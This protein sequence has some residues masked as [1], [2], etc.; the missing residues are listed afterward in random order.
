MRRL[1]LEARYKTTEPI[2]VLSRQE[3]FAADA[4][5]APARSADSAAQTNSLEQANVVAATRPTKHRILLAED[6]PINQQVALAMLDQFGYQVDLANNGQEALN[7]AARQSYDLVLM[8][9]Q[10]PEM[11]GFEAT[12]RIRALE[13]GQQKEMRWYTPIIA[14]TAHAME[15]DREYCLTAGMDDYMT[16]PFTRQQ[17]T[18]LLKRWLVRD[19]R[20]IECPAQDS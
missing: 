5:C 14:L 20:P 1:L 11:D 17:L 3:Q 16:K 8:D 15:T 10:M 9:C 6:N 13:E 12:R 18:D 2:Q 19:D 4:H 7:A